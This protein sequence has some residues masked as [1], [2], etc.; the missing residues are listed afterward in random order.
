MGKIDLS[1]MEQAYKVYSAHRR[2]SNNCLWDLCCV[3]EQT[4]GKYQDGATKQIAERL[5][6]S[7]N[8]VQDWARVGWLIAACDGFYTLDELGN[9][10]TLLDLWSTDKLSFDHLLKA[11]Q[12]MKRY[13]TTPELTLDNLLLALDG[14]QSANAMEHEIETQNE[15]PQELW[16]RDIGRLADRIEYNRKLFDYNGASLRLRRAALLLVGRIRQEIR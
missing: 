9:R 7:V 8:L 15:E 2:K 11:A 12:T 3:A 6:V 1:R 13:E 14:N 10:W 5:T 16:R 4:V